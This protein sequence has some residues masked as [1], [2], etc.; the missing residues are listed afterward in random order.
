VESTHAQ[1][2]LDEAAEVGRML[3]GLLETLKPAAIR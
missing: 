3:Q 2:I 1:P